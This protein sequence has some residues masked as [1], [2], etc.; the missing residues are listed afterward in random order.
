MAE[1]KT[2]SFVALDSI[3][4]KKL[5]SLGHMDLQKLIEAAL[6]EL[7]NKIILKNKRVSRFGQREETNKDQ[8]KINFI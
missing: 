7:K 1:N 3:F 5:C 2:E 8:E 6:F 4:F